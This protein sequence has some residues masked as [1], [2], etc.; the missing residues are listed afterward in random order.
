MAVQRAP[1]PADALISGYAN[2]S[3]HVDAYRVAVPA[4][5]PLSEYIT[6]FFQ[7][8]LFRMER[9]LLSAIGRVPSDADQIE[10]LALGKGSQMAAWK[11]EARSETEI[12]LAVSGAPIRTWL[13]T[14]GGAQPA[15]WF[16]SVALTRNGKL[17]FAVRALMPVHALYSRV[18]L[19]SAA[20]ALR[21]AP[22]LSAR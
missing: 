6:A 14:E 5:V 10:A 2:G 8:P 13:A 20:R 9:T 16:G 19:A 3:N 11:E 21:A 7:T 18:L 1:V 17:P 4:T 22:H 15:L 12:L